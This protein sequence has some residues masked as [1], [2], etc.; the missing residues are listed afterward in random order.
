MQ[1]SSH[2]RI[3]G[4]TSVEFNLTPGQAQANYNGHYVIATDNNKLFLYDSKSKRTVG[5]KALTGKD[6]L[7][8]IEHVQGTLAIIINSH[9]QL[10][11]IAYPNLNEVSSFELPSKSKLITKIRIRNRHV[12]IGD[13]QGMISA[14]RMN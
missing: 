14:L 6:V 3:N 4:L 10:T 12:F 2:N 5:A 13:E 1:D 9:S 7:V 11:V 8:D